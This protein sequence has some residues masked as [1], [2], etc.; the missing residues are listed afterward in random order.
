MT[1]GCPGGG[2]PGA[3]GT[4]LPWCGVP[5][6]HPCLAFRRRAEQHSVAPVRL[7]PCLAFRRRAEQLR[8]LRFGF[9]PALRDPRCGV[10]SSHSG[11]VHPGDQW[12]AR[13]GS[14]GRALLGAGFLLGIP[15]SRSADVRS[16]IRLLRFGFTPASRSADVRSNIQ[17]LRFGFTP[18]SRSADM[19]SN[20]RLLRFGVTPASRD[21]RC[22]VTSSHSGRVHPG[23]QWQARR[24]SGG[25]TFPG[26]G[27]L[28]GI[29]ASRSADMRSNIR[30]LRFGVT[31][32]SR[33]PRCG[34]T[35]SHSGRVHP[36]DQWQARRGSGGAT[37]PGAG[38]LLGI[39]ASRSADMRSNIRLLRFGVTHIGR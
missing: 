31:P 33:D 32:A 10:T 7:H 5:A 8:L 4:S 27:F 3:G 18:A 14:G 26:A 16:N 34:V 2:G 22:G 24:G 11:R 17:L 23:D 36:G 35:S 21:P 30:L 13:R 37:F 9:T 15:A 29:P 20:I 28:L 19:R 12:Q 39:P 6:R 38:F 25:A 1:G